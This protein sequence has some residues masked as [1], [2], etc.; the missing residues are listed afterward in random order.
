MPINRKWI[1]MWYIYTK[2]HYSAITKNKMLPF[3]TTWMDLDIILSEVSKRQTLYNITYMWNLKYNTNE[4]IYKTE[5]DSQILKTT[6]GYQ[7]GKQV[8][9]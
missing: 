1:K 8:G 4:L 3:T 7:R 2:E 5:T 9:V 6:Y